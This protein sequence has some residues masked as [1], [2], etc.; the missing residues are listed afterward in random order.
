MLSAGVVTAV[1][2]VMFS[3]SA[4]RIRL[5]TLGLLQYIT[6]TVQLLLGVCVYGEPFPRARMI[7]FACIW[8][9]LALYTTD[10]LIAQ[11]KFAAAV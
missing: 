2:L 3:Y 7:G 10:S 5:S 6:P 1:P 8:T 9:G 11:R 4:R